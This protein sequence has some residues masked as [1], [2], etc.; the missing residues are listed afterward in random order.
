MTKDTVFTL[1]IQSP[2]HTY[3]AM[4]KISRQQIDDIFLIFPRK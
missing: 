3:H 2:F 1:N 4:G